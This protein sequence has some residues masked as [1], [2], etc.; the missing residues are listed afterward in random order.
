VCP[1][2]LPV[3][4]PF[5][6][7]GLSV[8][9]TKIDN[10]TIEL[11]A[12]TAGCQVRFG[13]SGDKATVKPNQTCTLTVPGFGDQVVAIESWTLTLSGDMID[14]TTSGM[15]L[16][17]SASGSGVLVRGGPSGDAGAD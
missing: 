16:V 6:L 14:S 9:F 1:P 2:I 13:V 8:T 3:M 15:V 5:P 4:Q 11:V 17:C 10:S 12:G 7:T